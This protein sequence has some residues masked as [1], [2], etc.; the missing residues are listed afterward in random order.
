[1]SGERAAWKRK[2]YRTMWGTNDAE[3]VVSISRRVVKLIVI[4]P[5]GASEAHMAGEDLDKLIRRLT[6]FRDRLAK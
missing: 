6:S 4:T 2:R 3:V 1:M 5:K